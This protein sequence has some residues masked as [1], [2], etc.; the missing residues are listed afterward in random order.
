MFE[1]LSKKMTDA[2]SVIS[3]KSSLT[4]ENI[5]KAVKD[6]RVGLLEA[7]VALSVIDDFISKV[8][9]RSVGT[10]I[11]KGL[12]ASQQFI[13][14]VK[15]ELTDLMG[16]EGTSLDLA[17]QPPVVILVAGLQG[18]GKTTTVG[19]LSALLREREKKSVL[20]ASTDVQRP[21]A[22]EQLKLL[23][24]AAG[25]EFFP[26]NPTQS[27]KEIARSSLV[28]A[29]TQFKDVLIVDTAGRLSVDQEMMQELKD[30][31][32]V[33]EPKETLFVVDA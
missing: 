4:E 14:I 10:K 9:S 29:K 15:E 3:P 31:H 6:I 19:K 11:S 21:A 2:F 23:A 5:Q 25:V 20:V 1:T 28:Q 24:S 18:V 16:A 8:K 27:P 32:S 33:L 22:I 7:D 12:S 26:S 30:M 17:S 13:K